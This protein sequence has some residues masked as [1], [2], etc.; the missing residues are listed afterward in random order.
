MEK[1]NLIKKCDICDEDA[2]SLCFNCK[3]YF[4]ESCFKLIHNK[5]KN[6][7]H[8]KENIDP[9]VPIYLKCQEHQDNLISLFCLNE[10]GKNKII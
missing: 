8:K 1:K 4:C 6:A 10:K 9:Y 7:Q 5:Q 2:T 3:Q